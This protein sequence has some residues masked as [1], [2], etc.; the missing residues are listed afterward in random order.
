M[1]GRTNT[2]VIRELEKTVA[3]LDERVNQA[4]EETRRVHAQDAESIRPLQQTVAELITRLD[5]VREE[6]RRLRDEHTEVVRK[7]NEL[8]KRVAVLESQVCEIKKRLE[9][10]DKK[11]WALWLILVGSLMTLVVNVVLLLLGKK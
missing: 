10:R 3:A 5:H 4:R 1:A 8:D 6:A 2:E 11:A 7:S 9:E